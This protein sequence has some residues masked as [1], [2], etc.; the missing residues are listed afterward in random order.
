MMLNL[1]SKPA[2]G[3]AATL[4]TICDEQRHQ[5]ED[6]KAALE[7]ARAEIVKAK[8]DNEK[9]SSEFA[10]SSGRLLAFLQLLGINGIDI[11]DGSAL[12]PT[13][14]ARLISVDLVT[15]SGEVAERLADTAPATRE[16]IVYAAKRLFS[17][18]TKG[19]GK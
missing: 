18:S 7:A 17:A 4:R 12:W 6:L 1:K 13:Y 10:D 14:A 19:A 16:Q 15:N 5:I 9:M 3:D 11:A 8:S 2:S